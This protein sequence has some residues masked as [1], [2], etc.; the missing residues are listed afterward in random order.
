MQTE[1]IYWI[2]IVCIYANQVYP[3]HPLCVSIFL[4]TCWAYILQSIYDSVTVILVLCRLTVDL[5]DP[6]TIS[7]MHSPC[8]LYL[9][10][11]GDIWEDIFLAPH[12]PSR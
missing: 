9:V 2:L 8:H 5:P 11:I 6:A 3:R 4:N 10:V 1:F 7:E 12:V